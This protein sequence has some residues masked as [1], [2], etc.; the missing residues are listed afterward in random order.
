MYSLQCELDGLRS[1]RSRKVHQTGR[2]AE[3]KIWSWTRVAAKMCDLPRRTCF[4]YNL[5]V[6]DSSSLPPN[7]QPFQESYGH[8][9]VAGYLRR[10]QSWLDH[11]D[12][13]A[14]AISRSC[15]TSLLKSGASRQF[16]AEMCKMIP[17]S[18]GSELSTGVYSASAVWRHVVVGGK[19]ALVKMVMMVGWN[20]NFLE[21]VVL[22][23]GV[24]V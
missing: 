9:H 17:L 22:C 24:D 16:T 3:R 23:R 18:F 2:L 11:F 1:H 13:F 10:L 21:C 6:N 7:P 20:E 12:E 15:S 19:S 4:R 8:E 5:A 14:Y